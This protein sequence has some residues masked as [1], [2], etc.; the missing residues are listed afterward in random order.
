VHSLNNKLGTAV[1]SFS[2]VNRGPTKKK[3]YRRYYSPTTRKMV[4]NLYADDIRHLG[5]S[6]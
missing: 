5:Y 3:D 2:R 6:F 4:E 1:Q